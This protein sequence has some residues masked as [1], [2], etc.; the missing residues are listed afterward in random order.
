[1]NLLPK[2]HEEFRQNEYWETFSEREGKEPLN[3]KFQMFNNFT[4]KN[5][6]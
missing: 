6:F 2:N 1:M 5:W 3:G 4:H